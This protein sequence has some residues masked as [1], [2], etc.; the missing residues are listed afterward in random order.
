MRVSARDGREREFYPA[1]AAGSKRPAPPRIT[2]RFP[3]WRSRPS[4]RNRIRLPRTVGQ[5]LVLLAG[6]GVL[7][8]P[9]DALAG[10]PEDEEEDSL[11]PDGSE[12]KKP[13]NAWSWEGTP[14]AG[15]PEVIYGR[16]A[17]WY[18]SLT[19]RV[20]FDDKT[21]VGSEVDLE[22]DLGVDTDREVFAL[23]VRL[24]RY[25]WLLAGA[26]DVHYRGEA[27]LP[28]SVTFAG[29]T[30]AATEHIV[31]RFRIAVVDAGLAAVP[32]DLPYGLLGAIVGGTYFYANGEITSSSLG[33]AEDD[34]SAAVVWAGGVGEIRITRHVAIYALARGASGSSKTYDLKRGRFFEWRAGLQVVPFPY[35]RLGIEWRS[36]EGGAK[37][38]KPVQPAGIETQ[39]VEIGF[40]GP[41][42]T[43]TVGF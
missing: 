32:L 8:A 18:S 36:I 17:M 23:D 37:F 31:S 3:P 15:A 21:I 38:Q 41:M 29:V 4:R 7:R 14:F 24:G 13:R 40:R 22:R 16:G 28:V 12:E 27:D 39:D 43:A 42:F 30:Y 34:A 19:A 6:L 11:D 2:I 1:A 20:R 5:V 35:L 26:F 33:T 25:V 10:N 9:P